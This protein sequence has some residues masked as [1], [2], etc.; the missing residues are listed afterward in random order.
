MA[1][2][3]G[4]ISMTKLSIV[5]CSVVTS[6]LALITLKEVRSKAIA[7]TGHSRGGKTVLL[8]GATDERIALLPTLVTLVLAG[9]D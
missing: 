2:V 6:L 3:A 7:I 4:A 9:R 5:S 1:M 8:A